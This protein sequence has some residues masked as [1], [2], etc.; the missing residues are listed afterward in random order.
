MGKSGRAS[1]DESFVLKCVPR[2]FY[3]LSLRLLAE[4]AGS[5]RLR[6]HI[7]CNPEEG[8]LV[9]PYFRG[10]LL[11]LVQDDPDFPPAERKK[12]LRHVK[13]DNILV[14]WT[15]DKEG[16]KTVTDIALGDFDIA[17]KSDTGEPH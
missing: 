4:F 1:G 2:P 7:D 5:R 8:I 9:Y 13:P 17:S 16:N 12:I 10:T 6:M 3:D 15:C 11:A 14:N